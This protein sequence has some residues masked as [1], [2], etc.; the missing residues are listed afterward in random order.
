LHGALHLVGFKDKS[1]ADKERMRAEEDQYL[2]MVLKNVPRET[3][4]K[5][6]FHVKHGGRVS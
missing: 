6:R 1:Q 3:K 5:K 4:E 2:E